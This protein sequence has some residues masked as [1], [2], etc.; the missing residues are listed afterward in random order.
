MMTVLVLF[1]RV[2]VLVR[3]RVAMVGCVIRVVPSRKND[4]VLLTFLTHFREEN[5]NRNE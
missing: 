2:R 1:S 4:S 3:R 5:A